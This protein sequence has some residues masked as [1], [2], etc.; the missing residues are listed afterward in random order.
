MAVPTYRVYDAQGQK[1][2]VQVNEIPQHVLKLPGGGLFYSS[3]VE[4]STGTLFLNISYIMLYP[5][6]K[7]VKPNYSQFISH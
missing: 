3:F 4:Y 6:T 7:G 2:E 1:L 5:Q